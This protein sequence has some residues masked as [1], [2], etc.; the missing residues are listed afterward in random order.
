MIKHCSN[1]ILLENGKVFARRVISWGSHALRVYAQHQPL[2]EV[3]LVMSPDDDRGSQLL[4][5]AVARENRADDVLKSPER[6]LGLELPRY[7]LLARGHKTCRQTGPFEESH[8]RV[9]QLRGT[10]RSHEES[11]LAIVKHLRDPTRR[12]GYNRPSCDD[13][14]QTRPCR[15][16]RTGRGSLIR[17]LPRKRPRR[18]LRIP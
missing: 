2:D 9:A 17:R 8:N 4:L 12:C 15:K 6:T 10:I 16:P 1:A 13:R 14:P 3:D 18:A 5:L 11:V 7:P